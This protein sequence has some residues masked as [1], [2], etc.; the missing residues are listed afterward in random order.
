[1]GFKPFVSVSKDII[2]ASLKTDQFWLCN[3]DICIISEK[4]QVL[5]WEFITAGRSL[6]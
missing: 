2:H 1:V 3:N 5:D 6:T 4:E